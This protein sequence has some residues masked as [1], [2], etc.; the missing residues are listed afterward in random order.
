MSFRL[1]DPRQRFALRHPTDLARR[2]E[3]RIHA[4]GF[5]GDP[6]VPLFQQ[7]RSTNL[8]IAPTLRAEPDGLISAV[9]LYC[10]LEALQSALADVR[11]QARRLV[12]W[13][14]KREQ[15]AQPERA[16]PLRLGRPPGSRRTPTHEVDRVLAECHGLAFDLLRPNTS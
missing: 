3:P 9:A 11:G 1:V 4:F 15:P 6:R 8:G 12:R 13:R 2:L 7:D 16:S 5:G 14:T 10:R